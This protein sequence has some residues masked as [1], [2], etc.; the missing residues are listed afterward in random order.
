MPHLPSKRIWLAA[1]TPSPFRFHLMFHTNLVMSYHVSHISGRVAPSYH[2]LTTT[3]ELVGLLRL[4]RP[5]ILRIFS[6]SW[7][8]KTWSL[9]LV[10]TRMWS[11][12][13]NLTARAHLIDLNMDG[14]RRYLRFE[15][16]CTLQWPPLV[17]FGILLA[18]LLHH[19]RLHRS[20]LAQHGL[21]PRHLSHLHRRHFLNNLSTTPIS[22]LN[23]ILLPRDRRDLCHPLEEAL[24]SMKATPVDLLKSHRLT[25]GNLTLTS[26]TPTRSMGWI[27]LPGFAKADSPATKTLKVWIL[28]KSHSG[29]SCIKAYTIHGSAVLPT[30][31]KLSSFH[32]TT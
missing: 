30:D 17:L 27:S 5:I 32:L 29:N 11:L 3:A 12:L 31:E 28:C 23:D 26:M 4:F 13:H 14:T 6:T 20:H 16:R 9:S 10:K 8:P 15:D 24:P 1:C 2:L 18:Y 19:R 22:H 25:N 21:N 7:R